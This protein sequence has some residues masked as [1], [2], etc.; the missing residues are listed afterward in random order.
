MSRRGLILTLVAQAL[1]IA[2]LLT[3]ALDQYAHAQSDRLTGVNHRGYRGDVAMTHTRTEARLMLAGGSRAFAAGVV[4]HETM[5][6]RLH[7]SLTAKGA[8]PAGLLSA[9]N[10]AWPGPRGSYAARLD[11]F[12]SLAPDIVCIYVDLA[13]APSPPTSGPLARVGYTPALS[14]LGWADRQFGR[15]MPAEPPPT[16]DIRSVALAVTTA[17]TMS[18]G[19]IVAV[20]APLAATERAEYAALMQVLGTLSGNFTVVTV[21]SAPEGTPSVEAAVA[22]RLVE[23]VRA[24]LSQMLTR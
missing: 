21:P 10:V 3:L 5:L 8:Y 7:D 16:D 20:P 13:P 4:L 18:R 22:A 24:L 12:R 9:F 17:L 11:R 1:V 15:L 2:G 14:G 6:M 23:P 19:A